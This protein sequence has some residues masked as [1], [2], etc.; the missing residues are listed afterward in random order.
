MH[1]CCIAPTRESSIRCD[2]GADTVVSRVKASSHHL[3]R[4]ICT[5]MIASVLSACGGGDSATLIAG[6]GTSATGTASSAS[7]PATTT[8]NAAAAVAADN[9][10]V[11]SNLFSAILAGTQEVPVVA[12]SGSG[13]G[14]VLID[15]SSR[16]LRASITTT[17]IA[18]SAA[19]IQQAITGA[20]G[21]VV[22]PMVETAVGSGV[23]T[24]Q[25]TLTT[26]QLAT[27]I[28]GGYF[29]NVASPARPGGEIRGQ[30]LHQLP[31][32]G[33]TGAATSSTGS[34]LPGLAPATVGAANVFV[35]VLS[36][37][38]Q[39]PAS[40]STAMGVGVAL[41]SPSA[42][43]LTASVIT[44][45]MVG[46]SAAIAS[47]APGSIGPNVVSL[48]E[49]AAGSGIWTVRT[50]LTSAQSA[51]L[52]SGGDYI[53]VRSTAFPNG[54]IRG[55]IVSPAQAAA[56][57]A[58]AS[59]TTANQGATGA[60]TG[61]PGIAIVTG[62]PGS[63]GIT[64]TTGFNATS[65][66]PGTTAIT[67]SPAVTGTTPVTSNP[68]TTGIATPSGTTGFT[69]IPNTSISGI[70]S[71]PITGFGTSTIGIPI[72]TPSPNFSG[73][74]STG[75]AG[76]AGATGIPFTGTP[77]SAGATGIGTGSVPTLTP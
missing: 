37:A 73:I 62:N 70:G 57:G 21:P 19:S 69:T 22:F 76:S 15:S 24:V 10:L 39:V 60:A 53:H 46:S 11:P 44:S 52:T 12:S 75:I 28:A 65:G 50:N 8:T 56:I 71:P 51:T 58:S 34:P 49:T 64:G 36:A 20:T 26:D 33:G 18:G 9:G 6:S 31:S 35:N 55:Q 40:G 63:T 43:A 23:W 5:A 14:V 16:V 32:G 25:A 7:A 30:I 77:G 4:G 1:R 48:F 27:M 45:G 2:I 59:A 67:G 74:G 29:F 3:A 47:A 72:A 17:G 61:I 66:I 68:G 38:Q 54:E 42:L 41:V 13:V